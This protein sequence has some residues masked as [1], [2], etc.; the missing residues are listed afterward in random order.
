MKGKTRITM[1]LVAVLP[2]LL[3]APGCGERVETGDLVKLTRS[4]D[5]GYAKSVD[6]RIEMG[7]GKLTVSGGSQN[8]M[9]AEFTYNVAE[10]K[11]EVSYGEADERGTLRVRQP[12]GHGLGLGGRVRNEWDIQLNADIPMDLEV[13]LG[14]GTGRLELGDLSLMDLRI[15]AGAGEVEVLLTGQPEVD[16]L[17]VQVGAG[18]VT[19]DL[20]GEWTDDLDAEIKGGVG[21]LTLRLPTDVGVRVDADKG[22]GKVR[23]HGLRRKGGAYVNEAYGVSDVTLR[24]DC[25]AGVGSI[26]LETEDSS[27]DHGA[28]I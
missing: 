15:T 25:A 9:D 11:P 20:S 16:D 27:G 7:V 4:V 18:D 23:A 13:E 10:W 3:L 26:I 14:A 1:A 8:V 5:L 21:R 12:G 6:A 28:T 24:I 19:V 2:A 22:I 17:E